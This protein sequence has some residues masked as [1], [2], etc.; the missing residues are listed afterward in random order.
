MSDR[1]NVVVA[2][3]HPIFRRG[4]IE[5]LKRRPEIEVLDQAAD[6]AAALDLIRELSP[7]VAV[8][9]VQMPELGG[10]EVLNAVHRDGLPTRVMLLTGF[11]DS[12][13]AYEAMALGAG[14]YLS[15]DTEVNR[16]CDAI[17]AV[18]RG[19]TVIGDRFQS[20]LVAEIRLRESG[21]RPTLTEREREVLKLTSD[22]NSVSDVAAQLHLSDATVK[23]HLHHVYEKLEVS[24]RAAAVARAM[25]W[26]LIE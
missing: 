17:A 9:D 2:D 3:D 19:E 24:D 20:G 10:L 16:I 1:I 22:G 6:G 18:A 13:P 11:E 7:D 14:A 12:R 21:D 4:L 25:R 5:T 26:G 8:L 15:K 23:T